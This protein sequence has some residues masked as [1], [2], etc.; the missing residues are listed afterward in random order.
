MRS[1]IEMPVYGTEENAEFQEEVYTRIQH[2]MFLCNMVVKKSA[3]M[4]AEGKHFD[5]MDMK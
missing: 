4:E 1:M 5:I 3:K 2:H